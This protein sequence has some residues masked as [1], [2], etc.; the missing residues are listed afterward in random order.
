MQRPKSSKRKSLVPVVPVV[1][2]NIR[3]LAGMEDVWLADLPSLW[4]GRDTVVQCR[5]S[6]CF[7]MICIYIYTYRHLT[8]F[9]IEIPLCRSIFK[10]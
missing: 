4:P 9:E 1:P 7:S 2:V 3:E 6:N 5:S 10:A 8:A